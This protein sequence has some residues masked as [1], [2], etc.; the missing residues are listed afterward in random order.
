MSC[1]LA[2]PHTF[3]SCPPCSGSIISVGTDDDLDDHSSG[4]G[5]SHSSPIDLT[6]SPIIILNLLP[7]PLTHSLTLISPALH[8]LDINSPVPVIPPSSSSVI[9]SAVTSPIPA[10]TPSSPP[11]ITN[12]I[13]LDTEIRA[14][15]LVHLQNAFWHVQSESLEVTVSGLLAFII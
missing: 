2:C 10:Y 7:E 3:Q 4:T 6:D 9:T 13:S 5:S 12:L 8:N 11:F 1:Y 14:S 15:G